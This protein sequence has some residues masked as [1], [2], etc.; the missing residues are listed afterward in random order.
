MSTTLVIMAFTLKHDNM[1]PS[2]TDTFPLTPTGVHE[3][4]QILAPTW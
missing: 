2:A 4:L 1:G 3:T